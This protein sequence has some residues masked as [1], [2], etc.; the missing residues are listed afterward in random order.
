MIVK[1]AGTPARR[2][3]IRREV[4]P[5]VCVVLTGTRAAGK[6]TLAEALIAADKAFALVTAVTTR[7]PREDDLPSQY[8]HL[9]NERFARHEEAG[10]LMTSATYGDARYG[11]LRSSVSSVARRGKVPILVLTP[12]SSHGLVQQTSGRSV[13]STRYLS[14]FL[15]CEDQELDNRLQQRAGRSP[16]EEE[17]LQRSIDRSY[18]SSCVYDLQVGDVG[19]AVELLQALLNL[20]GSGG[21]IPRRLIELMILNGTL[22]QGAEL[23]SV[24]PASYDLRLG[25]EYYAAGKVRSLSERDPILLIEPYDFAIVTSREVAE[26]PREVSARFDLTVGLF[27]QGVILSNGPQID[28]GYRGG[29]F[30][31]LF[32]TSSRPILIKRGQHYATIEFHRLIEPAPPYG[33]TRQSVNL[34]D[35]LPSNV[36]V[37]AVNELKRDLERVGAQTLQ[38]Q[39]VIFTVL[40]LVLAIA[41]LFIA[42]RG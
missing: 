16:T 19:K 39:G 22:L 29:L 1:P 28:P 10:E 8:R 4:V 23:R 18:R 24:E 3:T 30:C 35:Y 11:V 13:G 20:A 25:D 27:S 26:L 41:A 12:E 38:A 33:G 17:R 32:N 42:T 34:V 7:P 36:V 15:D 2:S 31:L 5:P 6:T 21:V 9:S 37:G 40:S 14:V